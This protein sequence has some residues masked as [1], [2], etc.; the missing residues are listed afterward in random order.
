MGL[1]LPT[2]G[3]S[4]IP[5]SSQ[6]LSKAQIYCLDTNELLNFQFNPQTFQWERDINWAETSWRNNDYGGDLEYINSGP[7]TFDLPLLYIADPGAPDIVGEYQTANNEIAPGTPVDF[8][9]I[10]SLFERWAS[11]L[12][13]KKRPSRVRVIFGPRHFDGVIVHLD[14]RI[15]EAFEDLSTREG[16]ITVSF[17]EWK[18]TP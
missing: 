17:R 4:S 2:S 9:F 7:R 14:H 12:P 6:R 11:I 15:V 10:E 1:F 16:L 8:E 18:T 3:T 5:F 13:A